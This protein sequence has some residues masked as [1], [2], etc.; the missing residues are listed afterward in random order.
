[1]ASSREGLISGLLDSREPAVRGRTQVR[2]LGEDPESGA[3]K[4]LAAD[5]RASPRVRA[6][7]A[8]PHPRNVYAK[9]RGI[10]WV[11][12][13]LADLGCPRGDPE[14]LALLDP[15]LDF[16]LRDEFYAEFVASSRAGAYQQR[17]VPVMEGR[18][19]RCA[20]QQGNALYCVTVLG[21]GDDRASRL[22]ERLLHWQWPDG[23]WNCDKDP[24]ADTSSF[25]ETLIPMRGLWHYGRARGDQAAQAAALQAADVFL[26]RRLYRKRS[27][28][29]VI[30]DEFIRLH[31]PLYWHYDVL[32]GLKVI[33]ELGLISDP[34]CADALDLLEQKELPSGGWP[35]ERRHYQV[36]SSSAAHAEL[37]DWGGAS[38]V[39]VNQWVTTD[40]LYVLREAGRL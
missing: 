13:T 18:Y 33:A 5:V 27:D 9:W 12:A 34:R 25:M 8:G 32:G 23:G 28:G 35:A 2:V 30:R 22:V 19:R 14:V 29:N 7:L 1:M 40:A 16:W 38:T 11:V 4:R 21:T 6:L 37:V 26:S 31:Y 15:I 24:L 39:R 36:A 20:S 17:A 10:H 3:T